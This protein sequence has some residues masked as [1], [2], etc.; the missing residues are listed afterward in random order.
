MKYFVTGG[1]GFIGSHL[2]DR[3]LAHNQ[4]TVYDNL[5]SGKKKFLKQH[6]NSKNFRFIQ[7][8]LL[9]LDKL[10]QEMKNSDFVFHLAANPDIRYGT[11]HTDWDLKQGPIA[12]YNVLEAM[13]VNNIKKIAFSSSSVVYG[14]AKEIPTPED[15]G[16]LIP[17]S[18]YAASKLASEGLITAF[19]HT[20][21]IRSW[22]FRFANIIGERGTHGVIF[23]FIEKLK[24]DPTMLEILGDGKQRK[25]YMHVKDCVDGMI[26]A[27]KNSSAVVNVYNLGSDDSL[28]VNELAKIV[29]KKMDLNNVRIEYTG[30]KRGWKGDVVLMILSIDRIK[31]LGWSPKYNSKQAVE[32]AIDEMVRS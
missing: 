24:K 31:K 16:P 18:L 21:D 15:H 26:Y 29:I 30:G 9:D 10:K 17:I 2:V 3:L 11:K 27:I 12:T 23:D 14:E 7:G 4:V 20:F 32:K 25:S 19:C 22:I 1:A 6:E 28:S 8:D 5:S 13:R